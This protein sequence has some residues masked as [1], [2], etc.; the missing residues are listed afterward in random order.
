MSNL[1]YNPCF[2]I[3]CFN[4]GDKLSKVL[5]EL[6]LHNYPIIVIDDGSNKETKQTIGELKKKFCFIVI[7]LNTNR[8]KGG[9]LKFGLTYASKNQFTHAIQVD[10]DAQH[11]LTQIEP[12]I[13][14]SQSNSLSIISGRP[15]FGK[16]AP[17]SR[18]YS[19]YI[20]HIWVWLETCSFKLKDTLCGF[21]IYP[22]KS[23]L[24]LIKENRIGNY[25]DFDISIM[26]YAYWSNIDI[27]FLPVKVYYDPN[28]I[29]HFRPF[30][31]NIIISKMHAK[32][33]LQMFYRIPKLYFKKKQN[34]KWFDK[35][36]AGSILGM[37]I[38]F[39]VY[40]FL[41]ITICKCISKPI[42]FYYFLIHSREKDNMK[43]FLNNVCNYTSKP[44]AKL[45]NS[46]K[47]F[48]NFGYSMIDKIACWNG[49]IEKFNVDTSALQGLRKNISLGK[50]AIIISAHIGNIELLR[51][52]NQSKQKIKMNAIVYTQNALKF[53][54]IMKLINPDFSTNLIHTNEFNMETA[55]LISKKIEQGE[56]IVIM[57]DRI[58]KSNQDRVYQE[59][60]L[61][62]LANFPSGPFILASILKS[63]VFFTTVLFK[64]RKYTVFS[65]ALISDKEVNE[66]NRNNRIEVIKNNYIQALEKCCL[67]Y[68]HQWFNFFSFWAKNNKGKYLE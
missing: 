11:D 37:K 46:F 31:D 38:I 43:A 48:Q 4:H 27:K 2:L 66:L 35:K 56:L 62:Q 68:P 21:R 47:S 9:A 28:N 23:T 29:S 19:R 6:S 13:K 54:K 41:G 16:D 15:I 53:N 49:D 1:A 50:G 17:K 59:T 36:E 67:K 40:R 34:F 60:F 24:K 65:E 42:I 39:L 5:S 12:L 32:Q 52:L 30:K 8:G 61:G 18:V 55:L 7:Q 26:V 51:S 44:Q 57:G 25:M 58:P 3:P 33:F 64:D 20:T 63:P 14:L 22:I 45:N 10:A